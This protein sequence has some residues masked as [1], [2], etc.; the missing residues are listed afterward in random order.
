LN[1]AY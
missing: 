1:W